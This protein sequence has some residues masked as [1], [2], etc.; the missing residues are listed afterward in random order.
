MN[1]E[2]RE[3]AEIIVGIRPGPIPETFAQQVAVLYE[4][5]ER[6]AQAYLAE[7]DETAVDEEWLRSVCFEVGNRECW[8]DFKIAGHDTRLAMFWRTLS[9][10]HL[11]ATL[12]QDHVGVVSREE[13]VALGGIRTRGEL[14]RLA[15]AL[16]IPLKEGA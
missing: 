11:V 13:C 8:F 12:H 4:R 14:R 9:C 3:A 2:L 10:K 15:S 1:D 16:G 7:H 5:A 6:L